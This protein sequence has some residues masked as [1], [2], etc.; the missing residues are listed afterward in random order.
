MLQV[1]DIGHR[2]HLVAQAI[3]QAAQACSG[4]PQVPSE[5]RDTIDKLDRHADST[6]DILLS[7]D[8]ARIR[9]L[10]AEMDRLAERA[11]RVCANVPQLSGQMKGAVSHLCSQIVELK[12]DVQ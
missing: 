6:R 3:G 9:K 5:L 7:G 11:R 4:E 2:F 8:Q 1:Y 12:R 10:I